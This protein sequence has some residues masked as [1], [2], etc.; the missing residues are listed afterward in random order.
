MHFTVARQRLTL[1]DQIACQRARASACK[2]V[3]RLAG[4]GW[5]AEEQ[6][7]GSVVELGSR[8]GKISLWL[9]SQEMA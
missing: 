8:G 5:V 6:L 7:D 1:G 2:C 3:F 9:S 4:T